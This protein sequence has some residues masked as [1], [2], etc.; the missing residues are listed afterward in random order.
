MCTDTCRKKSRVQLFSIS[1]EKTVIE[2]TKFTDCQ[3]TIGYGKFILKLN[4]N[5]KE[6]FYFLIKKLRYT[7]STILIAVFSWCHGKSEQ[8]VSTKHAD[9]FDQPEQA[10]TWLQ[11]CRSINGKFLTEV[12][13][14]KRK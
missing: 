10:S 3:F 5:R 14:I 6:V 11:M 1:M 8:Q 12:R 4:K 2:P 7:A 9:R 13:L